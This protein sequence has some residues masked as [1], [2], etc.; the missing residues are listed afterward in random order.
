MKHPSAVGQF[1]TEYCNYAGR[2]TV[3]SSLGKP[4]VRNKMVLT[5]AM[6]CISAIDQFTCAV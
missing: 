6:S 2:S 4:C 3:V 5:S 1:R